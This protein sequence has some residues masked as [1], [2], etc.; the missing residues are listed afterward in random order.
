VCPADRP[1]G[2][3]AF[4]LDGTLTRGDSVV[5]GAPREDPT[6]VVLA[7]SVPRSRAD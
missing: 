7:W 4:D 1:I 2:L 3:V 5:V 6:G